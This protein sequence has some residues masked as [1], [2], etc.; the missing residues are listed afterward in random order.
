MST[1]F[2]KLLITVSLVFQAYL[3]F[4]N[5]TVATAFNTKLQAALEACDCIPADIA[6][7]ILQHGRL[8][9]VGLLGSSVLMILSR[10]WCIKLLPLIALSALLYIEHQPFTKIPC[11]GCTRLWEK[12]AVIGAIIYLMGSDCGASSCTKP[13]ATKTEKSSKTEKAHTA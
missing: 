8:V 4:E 10:C 9:I 7:H 5:Q 11:I 3:L 6:G 2:G 13:C 12:V 1:W